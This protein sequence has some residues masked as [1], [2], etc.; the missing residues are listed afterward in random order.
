V[1]EAEGIG[2]DVVAAT[3]LAAGRK[4]MLASAVFVIASSIE[5]PV[6]ADTRNAE[7]SAVDMHNI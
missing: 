2:I 3:P 7:A 5:S 4:S 1:V 6:D